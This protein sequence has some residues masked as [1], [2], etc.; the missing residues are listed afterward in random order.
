M[1]G[2]AQRAALLEEGS[3]LAATSEEHA[4]EMAALRA[5]HDAAKVRTHYFIFMYDTTLRVV[6]S[7]PFSPVLCV[8][9]SLLEFMLKHEMGERGGGGDS[10]S[11]IIHTV[12]VLPEIAPCAP[13][14]D[15]RSHVGPT[16]SM[17]TVCSGACWPA[18]G[19]P[20]NPAVGSCAL[21]KACMRRSWNKIPGSS[22]EG[23]REQVS[24]FRE[25]REQEV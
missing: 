25:F 23:E 4:R 17:T 16:D 11:C 18:P 6:P 24:C 5:A 2:Q 13:F 3:A 9:I 15:G 19:Q 22:G 7:F 12:A 1:A 21:Q 14:M 20:P 10:Q 8:S